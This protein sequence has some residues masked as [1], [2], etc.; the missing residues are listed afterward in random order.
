MGREKKKT[1]KEKKSGKKVNKKG[2]FFFRHKGKL[3]RCRLGEASSI[4]STPLERKSLHLV[5]ITA[6]TKPN[7]A[8]IE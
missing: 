5:K 8:L 7:K 4:L 6:L 1:T 2:E 3:S